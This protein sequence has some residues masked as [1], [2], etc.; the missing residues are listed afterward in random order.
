[1]ILLGFLLVHVLRS[2]LLE[3][4]SEW[5][6]AAMMEAVLISGAIGNL[7]RALTQ[8]THQEMQK[9]LSTIRE[10]QCKSPLNS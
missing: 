7:G 3:G 5:F 6:R 4:G 9:R 1:M 2:Y 8:E 10:I